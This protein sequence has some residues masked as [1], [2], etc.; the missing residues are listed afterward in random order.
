MKTLAAAVVALDFCGRRN[1]DG[2]R[3]TAPVCVVSI[4]QFAIRSPPCRE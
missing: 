1:P 2:Q 4:A 3:L